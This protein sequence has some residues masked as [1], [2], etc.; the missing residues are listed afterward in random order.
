M[1]N[2]DPRQQGTV[3]TTMHRFIVYQYGKVGSTSIV[4]ALNGLPESKAF[5][6]HFL[7]EMAFQATLQRLMDPGVPDYFFEHSAGQLIKNLRI[8][9][10]FLLRGQGR[11]RLTVIT[12]AREPFDWFRSSISQDINQHIESLKTMLRKQGATWRDDDDALQLGMTLVFERLLLAIRHFG[13]VDA[14]CGA[15]RFVLKDVIPV[16]DNADFQS[17]MFFL[18]IFLR[19]HLWFRTHFREVMQI[20]I[21]DMEAVSSGL[22]RNRQGWGNTYLIRYEDLADAFPLMLDDLGFGKAVKLPR[23]N[24]SRKKP[25]SRQ[26]E[27]LFATGPALELRSLC[28]SEDTRFLGYG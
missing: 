25:Y 23:E 2:R 16:A 13:S 24:E 27:R 5:Q 19:P 21:R 6:S 7:G 10:H 8:Y 28:T 3:T 15:K 18:N 4:D 11:D 12:L 20:D 22:F 14:T 1:D 26:L 9:R 17:F